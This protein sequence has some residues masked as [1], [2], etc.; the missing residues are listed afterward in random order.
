MIKEELRKLFDVDVC[1]FKVN[2]IPVSLLQS[3]DDLIINSV[4]ENTFPTEVIEVY[5]KFVVMKQEAPDSMKT[6]LFVTI[7]NFAKNLISNK[8]FVEAFVL[9]RFLIVKSE[10]IPEDYSVIAENLVKV[11]EKELAKTFMLIYEKKEPN[12]VL[13]FLTLANFYNLQIGDYKKAIKYYEKYVEIDKT[14]AVIYSILGNLYSKVYGE[15]SLSEQIF[16]FEKAY[17]L[18]PTSRLVLHALAFAYEKV[19]NKEKANRYYKEILANN[20]TEIDYYNYGA[21][22]IS[23]GDFEQGHKYFR[24]RFLID[25]ENLKY[26]IDN[27]FSK[28]WDLV[29]DISDKVLLVHYEQGFG[30]TFMYCRFVPLLKK[31]ARKVIFV[32]QDSLFDLIKNSPIISEGIEV[33]SD[34]ISVQNIYYDYDMALLDAPFVL[35]TNANSI[36]YSQGY[37][38]VNNQDVKNYASKYLKSSSNLKVGIAYSGD[39]NSNYFGRDIDLNKFKI[40]TN[41]D[42][43]EVYSLQVGE[44]IDNP[45]IIDLGKT[46]NNFTDTACAIKNMDIIISTDN[47]ILNLAGALGAKTFGLFNKQTNYRWFKTTG[48]NVG[49]YRS[50]KPLQANIQDDWTSVFSSVVNV[51]SEYHS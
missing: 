51:L 22:L 14:K 19:G 3:F 23:C 43:I 9:Y 27:S 31:L 4:N 38:T 50:V 36:P 37:L 7:R 47:V 18:N 41:L 45:K 17:S 10:L 2:D 24:Y 5:K 1:P 28:K 25:D 39:K 49:W 40:L 48:E 32:V 33:L 34:K 16:Y 44:E 13:M 30:D 35:K 46:F 42:G 8:I 11:G 21:F 26:P 20:P 12:K 29:S 6:N 15:S